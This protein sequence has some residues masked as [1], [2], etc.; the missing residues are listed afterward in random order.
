[1]PPDLFNLLAQSSLTGIYHVDATHLQGNRLL[2]GIDEQPVGMLLAL[3]PPADHP[4]FG[5]VD[6]SQRDRFRGIFGDSVEVEMGATS[7]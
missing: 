4:T 3:R 5:D 1:M 2:V 7:N 6:Q